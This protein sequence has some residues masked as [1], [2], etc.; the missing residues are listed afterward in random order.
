MST[1]ICIVVARARNGVIGSNNQLP[2][3]LPADMKHFKKITMGHPVIMGRKT[4]E[5]IGKPLPGRQNIVITTNQNYQA[6]ECEVV[7]SIEQAIE[8]AK[9]SNPEK[10]C[11]LGGGQIFQQI[12]PLTGKIYLTE[13]DA[14]P[15]GNVYFNFDPKDWTETSSEAHQA[16]DKN[17]YN[18]QFI[19]LERASD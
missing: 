2:W 14:V 1:E 4:H 12:L 13:V 17:P 8:I 18:Y 15:D 10:I 9:Q 7:N 3:K 11:C 6:P 19:E 16:D 5:S